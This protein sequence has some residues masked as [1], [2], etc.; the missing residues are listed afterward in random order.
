MSELENDTYHDYEFEEEL[1]GVHNKKPCPACSFP[2]E[3]DEIICPECA[4]EEV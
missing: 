1:Y 2:I 4:I 3:L